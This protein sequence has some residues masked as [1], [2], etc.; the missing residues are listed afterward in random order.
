MR[1]EG[2]KQ[3]EEAGM[4]G[5]GR[6]TMIYSLASN[7]REIPKTMCVPREPRSVLSLTAHIKHLKEPTAYPAYVPSKQTSL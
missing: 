2:K 4:G 6:G 5:E 7:C 3:R 1:K